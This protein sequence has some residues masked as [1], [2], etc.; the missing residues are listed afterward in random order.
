MCLATSR[1]CSDWSDKG[2]NVLKRVWWVFEAW[3]VGRILMMALVTGS[4]A[5][6]FGA[7][8]REVILA[9][10]AAA[11]LALGGFY[12]DYLADRQ[13]DRQSGKMLNPVASGEMSPAMGWILVVVSLGTS[14]VLGAL[15]NPWAVLPLAGVVAVVGG[16]A[17]GILDTP[18][19]RAVSLGVLQGLYVLIGGI[20]A[21]DLGW[22]VVLTALFLLFAM[23]GGR[24]MGEVRDLPYD[25]QTDT[26]TIPKRYG[27]R[28]ATGFLLINEVISYAVSLSVYWVA[29]MAPGYLYCVLGI[30]VAGTVLN[31]V[32][33]L[34][35]VPRVADVTNKLSFMLLGTLYVLGMVLGRR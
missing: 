11:L 23:T 35:P 22:G 33:A 9:S 3:R 18:V 20:A 28:W 12:L 30:V 6:G 14:A 5:Y 2:D 27:A 19:L 13:R 10:V 17:V 31:L 8:P 15:V 32:F 1:L 26:E 16:L 24:V 21:G 29:P 7:L 25:L 4:T 34:K